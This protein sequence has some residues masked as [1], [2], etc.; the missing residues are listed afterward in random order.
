M[1]DSQ[2][3]HVDVSGAH[4]KGLCSYPQG[5]ISDSTDA[6]PA[7]SKVYRGSE[8]GIA[9]LSVHSQHVHHTG[10]KLRKHQVASSSIDRPVTSHFPSNCVGTNAAP[11]W[12]SDNRH[13][14]EH[15]SEPIIG[16]GKRTRDSQPEDIAPTLTPNNAGVNDNDATLTTNVLLTGT[17]VKIVNTNCDSLAH[18]LAHQLESGS[19]SHPCRD[20]NLLR[21]QAHGTSERE[22]FRR[23]HDMMH[24][25]Q[26]L[27][28]AQRK[29]YRVVPSGAEGV[30]HDE[31]FAEDG[32][33]V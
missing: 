27:D 30:V 29:Q 26:V 5:P 12:D 20:V 32:T 2:T 18:T 23:N 24:N 1:S 22:R 6:H 28:P 4:K 19:H 15:R 33:K 25:V 10:P 8:S 14:I 13:I 9:D 7:L 3:C 16:H 31:I 17:P 21:A 11:F